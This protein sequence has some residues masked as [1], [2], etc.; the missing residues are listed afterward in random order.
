[1]LAHLV[2]HLHS[3]AS[4]T[5]RFMK[6]LVKLGQ[7]AN[8]RELQN[9]RK[10]GIGLCSSHRLRLQGM[11]SEFDITAHCSQASDG[12]GQA[13]CLQKGSEQL[14]ISGLSGRNL[15]TSVTTTF[16]TLLAELMQIHGGVQP[17][18]A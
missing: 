15:S 16:S 18:R 6:I 14:Q 5:L 3:F 2:C 4:A 9:K 12:T 13:T 10:I 17:L 11:K 8:T 1:M 7:D